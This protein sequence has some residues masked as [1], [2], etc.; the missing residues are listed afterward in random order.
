MNREMDPFH[1]KGNGRHWLKIKG[2]VNLG[3]VKRKT[4]LVI[5]VELNIADALSKD[6]DIDLSEARDLIRHDFLIEDV[7]WNGLT[8]RRLHLEQV[9]HFPELKVVEDLSEE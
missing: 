7:S 4:D 8:S 5:D 1:Y 3:F 2:H 6:L 9:E